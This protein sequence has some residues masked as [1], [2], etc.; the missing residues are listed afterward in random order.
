MKF[1]TGLVVVLL[2]SHAVLSTQ[3]YCSGMIFVSYELTFLTFPFED[4]QLN[5]IFINNVGIEGTPKKGWNFA[6]EVHAESGMLNLVPC[7]ILAD[8]S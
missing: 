3:S 7:L 2:V 8:L 5:G 4:I 6:F 1:I